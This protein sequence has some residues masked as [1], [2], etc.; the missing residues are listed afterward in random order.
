MILFLQYILFFQ[1][2]SFSVSG[3]IKLILEKVACKVGFQKPLVLYEYEHD[4]GYRASVQ[5][6][7]LESLGT[8]N[9]VVHC[10]PGELRATEREVANSAM[11]NTIEVLACKFGLA[12][13]DPS[14]AMLSDLGCLERA[15]TG[16]LRLIPECACW[17]QKFSWDALHEIQDLDVKY[18]GT[19]SERDTYIRGVL[20]AMCYDIAQHMD[21]FANNLINTAKDN[22]RYLPFHL[23]N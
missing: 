13:I 16:E 10:V 15:I 17:F 18:N 4:K 14:S 7:P 23:T 8:P 19:I 21:S 20:L 2:G 9:S 6:T 5:L 12:I 11:Y 1:E 22:Y 3:G